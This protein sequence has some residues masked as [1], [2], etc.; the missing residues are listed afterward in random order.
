MLFVFIALAIASAVY[1]VVCFIGWRS[2]ICPYCGKKDSIRR[3][4]QKLK[5]RYCK[6][7]SVRNGEILEVVR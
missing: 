6:K 4:A 1:G 3:N 5:C 7:I 2:S